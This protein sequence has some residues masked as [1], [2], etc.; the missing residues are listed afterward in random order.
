MNKAVIREII[1][2]A[3]TYDNNIKP[4]PL[5]RLSSIRITP[6][7]NKIGGLACE[8]I[9]AI[10]DI[11]QSPIE[12]AL[13]SVLASISLAVQPH[14][15]IKLPTGQVKPISLN[16]I[17]IAAS[18]ERK[19]TCD[20]LALAAINRF[21]QIL[22]ES[23]PAKFFEYK[24]KLEIYEKIRNE[25]LK[26][27]NIVNKIEA[28]SKIGMPP[29]PPTIPLITCP[30]PT[31]EGLCKMLA[32]SRPSIGIFSSEGGQFI[33][34]HAMREE[35]KLMTGA[36]L[37]E[38]FDGTP[39]KRVRAI[40][41]VNILAGKRIAMHLM[42][43]PNA[44]MR[45]LSDPVL[46]DQGF[47]SRILVSHPQTSAGTRFSREVNPNSLNILE[48]YNDYLFDLLNLELQ[49]M[50]SKNNELNPRTITFEDSAKQL[51]YDYADQIEKQIAPN[52]KMEIIKGFACKL[53]EH[54]TRIACNLALFNDINLSTLSRDHLMI[55]VLLADYYASEILRIYNESML[56]AEL[57]QAERLRIWL[58]NNWPDDH[59]SLPNIY[60]NLNFVRDKKTASKLVRVL[61]EHYWLQKVESNV[62]VKGKNRQD[63]WRINRVEV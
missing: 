35:T 47:L 24:N 54:A 53:P 52:E 39:I 44:A 36:A 41:G 61:E 56:D 27:K 14:A 38:I 34:G 46:L 10:H 5:T 59:I 58:I 13:N 21:E 16:I 12:I 49:V 15:N 23:Y 45:L 22:R 2:G 32:L 50:S 17:T 30:E 63:V 31:F 40:D 9:N 11:T 8:A 3:S 7:I 25:I 48:K 60:Q 19:T 42:I 6:P 1:T 26:N 18:G 20:N 51:F 4:E 37:S 57:Q 33:G 43:Q 28:L 29:E 55:G 62:Q